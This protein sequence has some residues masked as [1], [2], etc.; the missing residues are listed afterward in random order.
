[1]HF[2]CILIVN[3][4]FDHLLVLVTIYVCVCVRVWLSSNICPVTSPPSL[5][6][7]VYSP[8]CSSSS[9]A[10]E[11]GM[12]LTYYMDILYT[13]WTFIVNLFFSTKGKKKVI[14]QSMIYCKCIKFVCVFYLPFFCGMWL[15]L[16]EVIR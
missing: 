3:V 5:L 1:M 15:P 8:L 9:L 10:N 7:R 12:S 14:L 4:K 16:N 6:P 13:S 11:D 2:E